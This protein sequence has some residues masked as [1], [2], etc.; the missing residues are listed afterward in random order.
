MDIDKMAS[1]MKVEQADRMV[2][3]PNFDM[4]KT[5]LPPCRSLR[6]SSI[7]FEVEPALFMPSETSGTLTCLIKTM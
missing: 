7:V 3:F 6:T 2:I 1:E 4:T 5:D